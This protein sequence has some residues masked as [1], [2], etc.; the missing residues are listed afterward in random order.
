MTL[1]TTKNI[2]IK[3]T[4]DLENWIIGFVLLI[5]ATAYNVFGYIHVL[6]QKENKIRELKRDREWEKEKD[7]NIHQEKNI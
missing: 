7:I 5:I 3:N 6:C 4:K 1:P 2:I